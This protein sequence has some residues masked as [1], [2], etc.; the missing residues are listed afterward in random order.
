[1][2]KVFAG[3]VAAAALCAGAIALAPAAAADDYSY[4]ADLEQ[5]GFGFTGIKGTYVWWGHAVCN[6]EARG[7]NRDQIV[8]NVINGN[9]LSVGAALFVVESAEIHIC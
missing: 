1:M 2:K 3:G 6:D 4:I 7:M 5:S 8:R 9:N